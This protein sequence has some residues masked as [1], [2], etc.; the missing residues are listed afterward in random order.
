[1][2]KVLLFMIIA[3]SMI[4]TSVFAEST[5]E[6]HTPSEEIKALDSILISGKIT[7]VSQFKLVKLRVIGPDGAL[8]FCTSSSN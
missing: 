3:I 7:D 2:L 5:I 4:S 8:V 1:M 6:V